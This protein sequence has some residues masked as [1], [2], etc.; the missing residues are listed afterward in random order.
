MVAGA[1]SATAAI[2]AG[3]AGDDDRG[4]F[5]E[6]PVDALLAQPAVATVPLAFAVMALV[7]LRTSAPRR[8]RDAMLALHLPD[9]L[10]PSAL[11]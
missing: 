9:G 7:S 2:V 5:A 1:V 11:R 8:T 4:S 10:G 6:G 3:L